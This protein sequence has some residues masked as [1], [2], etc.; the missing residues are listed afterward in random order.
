MTNQDNLANSWPAHFAVLANNQRNDETLPGKYAAIFP[1]AATNATCIRNITS[2]PECVV[3]IATA[4]KK[5]RFLHQFHHDESTPVRTGT[6]ELWALLGTSDY[7]PVV[8]LNHDQLGTRI[9]K[10]DVPC[11]T[12][13]RDAKTAGEFQDTIADDSGEATGLNCKY[14]IAVPPVVAWHLIRAETDDPAELGLIAAEAIH[15]ADKWLATAEDAPPPARVDTGPYSTALHDVVAFL[16][17]AAQDGAFPNPITIETLTFGPSARWAKT[18]KNRHIIQEDPPDQQNGLPT[19]SQALQDLA[20]S[21][22][23]LR[24]DIARQNSNLN[25]ARDETNK[26]FKKFPSPVQKMILRASEPDPAGYCAPNGTLNRTAP[27]STYMEILASGSSAQALAVIGFYLNDKFKL[28]SLI[29]ASLAVA[30]YTGNIKWFNRFTRG[31][32][33]I[34]SCPH[35]SAVGFNGHSEEDR[36][37]RALEATEGKGISSAQA[38]SSSKIV[39]TVIIDLHSLQ[40]FLN[41]KTHVNLLLFGPGSPLVLKL[42]VWSR[43]IAEHRESFELLASADHTFC[44][45]VGQLWDMSEQAFL[46][47]C[48]AADTPADIDRNCLDHSMFQRQ[49]TMGIAPSITLPS[50]LATLLG[51]PDRK[52]GRSR[53][54]PITPTDSSDS[55]EPPPTKKQRAKDNK[56][57]DRHSDAIAEKSVGRTVP[58]HWSTDIK[59]GKVYYKLVQMIPE[60]VTQLKFEDGSICGGL[61]LRGKCRDP[62]NC[63]HR[64]SHSLLLNL[65]KHD[66]TT[67]KK[68]FKESIKSIA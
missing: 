67:T 39:H 20:E 16:W 65:N 23:G 63:R 53:G 1:P 27:V 22:K 48:I 10:V 59:D 37:Q 3:M 47:N 29:A 49:I 56:N 44:S 52:K 64:K 41:I 38:A 36:T 14:V 51:T 6:N 68:W 57:T 4:G 43:V 62:D 35:A 26:V 21:C 9:P 55:D 8:S 5:I 17:R 60:L 45:Q 28:S 11:W 32:F 7:A 18:I 24:V 66:D 13:L 54:N 34:F 42:Q 50:S 58:T 31:A 46:Q 2:V 61:L 30:I 19:G 33:S 40:D 15:E 25:S 12:D